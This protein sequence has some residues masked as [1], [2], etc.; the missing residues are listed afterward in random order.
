MKLV[1][2]S[3][4]VV[5]ACRGCPAHGDAAREVARLLEARGLCE[6]ASDIAKARARYPV[7]AIDGCA[8]GCVRRWLAEN[9]IEPQ[10]HYV[11]AG[12]DARR[13][14]EAIAADLQ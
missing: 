8:D 11:V 7:V 5:Y 2:R 13:S 4:G 10:R 3:L 14:C 1:L 6:T 12:T 9:G